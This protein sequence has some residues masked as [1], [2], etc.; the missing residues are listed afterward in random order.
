MR[1][2]AKLEDKQFPQ[3]ID[4]LMADNFLKKK[5][6]SPSWVFQEKN[7]LQK[8]FRTSPDRKKRFDFI[9]GLLSGSGN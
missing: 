5:K 1:V 7:I 6:K 2:N 3:R 8:Q 9:S 4:W